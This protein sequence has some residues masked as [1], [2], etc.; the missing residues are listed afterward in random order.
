MSLE[1]AVR[2][3]LINDATV[4]GLVVAR[5]YPQRRPQGS[6]LPAIVYQNVHSKQSESLQTQSSI[7][8]TRLG[9]EAIS[10]T[11][12][13]TKT[14][15]NAIESALVNYA[16]TLEGETIHSLRLESVVDIDETKEPAS[17]FGAF[18]TIMDFVI[19]HE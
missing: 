9:V 12:G 19:W 11:Y 1:K 5:V 15:R 2:S 3:V 4:A 7:R 6:T 18:R 8:R 13:G 16:G 14:L 17:Q 10:A